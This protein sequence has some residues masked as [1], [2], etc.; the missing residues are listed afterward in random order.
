[1]PNAAQPP[2]KPI[3][4]VMDYAIAIKMENVASGTHATTGMKCGKDVD[5][6]TKR[7]VTGAIARASGGAPRALNQG[8]TRNPTAMR[9]AAAINPKFVR[10]GRVGR[11][12][13]RRGGS[14][15]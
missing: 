15:G 13:K 14:A 6:P 10:S 3:S 8:A 1:M 2:A 4:N 11:R 12:T 5:E 7:A 9:N